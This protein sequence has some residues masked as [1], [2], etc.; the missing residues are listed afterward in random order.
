MKPFDLEAAKRGDPIVCRDGRP[1]KFI[2]H[3]PEARLGSVVALVDDRVCTYY[4]NGLMDEHEVMFYSYT[5]FMAPKTRTVWVNFF[6]HSTDAAFYST[7]EHADEQAEY[8]KSICRSKRI[9][10]RAYPVE[11]EE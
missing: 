4:E 6:K 11:V 3:V 5:L 1:A 8:R 10:N 9:G 2:A 7:K